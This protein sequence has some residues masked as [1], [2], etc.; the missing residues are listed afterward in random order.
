MPQ[1]CV[2]IDRW[3]GDDEKETTI[4]RLQSETVDALMSYQLGI[5]PSDSTLAMELERIA[6]R[7]AQ[8]N[9]LSKEDRKRITAC[10]VATYAA[11]ADIP[12]WSFTDF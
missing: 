9:P 11:E 8:Q 3:I 1:R 7:L 5:A 2:K 12:H 6:G 10:W 4:Y